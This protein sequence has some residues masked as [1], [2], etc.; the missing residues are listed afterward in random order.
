MSHHLESSKKVEKKRRD[1]PVVNLSEQSAAPG[2]S[3][4]ERAKEISYPIS[5]DARGD[6]R[7]SYEGKVYYF[8][9]WDSPQSYMVFALWKA[10]AIR[11]GQ[12]P[13]CRLVRPMAK[14]AIQG[15]PYNPPPVLSR[16]WIVTAVFA[17][18]ITIALATFAGHLVY[19]SYK[20]T[21]LDGV[22][23]TQSEQ[24]CIRGIRLASERRRAR[25]DPVVGIAGNL[26]KVYESMESENGL[27]PLHDHKDAKKRP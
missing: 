23:L 11:T 24:D 6:A 21:E 12:P 3:Q 15:R 22:P 26:D 10:E 9:V 18:L 27:Q 5:P 17:G 14:A 20:P 25:R 1:R 7:M 13:E 19:S 16:W 8:G 4:I 2:K